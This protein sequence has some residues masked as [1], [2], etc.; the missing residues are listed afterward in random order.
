MQRTRITILVS[1]CLVLLWRKEN[2]EQPKHKNRD[3]LLE[4]YSKRIFFRVNP[5]AKY[6][7][8][9]VQPCMLNETIPWREELPAVNFF[10]ENMHIDRG[11]S[12]PVGWAELYDG[13]EDAERVAKHLN[14]LYTKGFYRRPFMSAK[15]L[16]EHKGAMVKIEREIRK[17][18][19]KYRTFKGIYFYD[20]GLDGIQIRGHHI[21]VE[22]H[23]FG[24]SIILK[25]DFSNK[26]TV[27]K[28]FV[29]MWKKFDTPQRVKE[30]KSFIKDGRK[31]GW[32]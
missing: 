16:E 9:E 29:E 30:Y 8:V 6:K 7:N 21:K 15:I 31:Y 3:K 18:L 27:V 23:T 2:V 1:M 26:D 32:N 22:G 5:S 4:K 10:D 19:K 25:R 17:G 13:W 28:E 20:V 11:K 24:K 14:K 12:Y